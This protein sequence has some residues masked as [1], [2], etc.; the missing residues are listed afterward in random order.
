MAGEQVRRDP[1]GEDLEDEDTV[2]D[3]M[4]AWREY[5][6]DRQRGWTGW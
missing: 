2:R 5:E 1:W 6:M 3:Q 4:D